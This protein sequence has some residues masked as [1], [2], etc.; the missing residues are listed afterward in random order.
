MKQV[1]KKKERIY[2]TTYTGEIKILKPIQNKL[3][4]LSMYKQAKNKS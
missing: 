2:Y 4:I 3:I 1:I